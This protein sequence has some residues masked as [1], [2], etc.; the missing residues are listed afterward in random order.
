MLEKS[1]NPS[2]PSIGHFSFALAS[3]CQRVKYEKNLLSHRQR[4]TISRVNNLK[5]TIVAQNATKTDS[6][7]REFC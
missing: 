1:S 3:C 6:L 7:I 4:K 2:N 5:Y